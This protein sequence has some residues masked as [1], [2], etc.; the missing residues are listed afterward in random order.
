[1]RLALA[2]DTVLGRRVAGSL[3]ARGPEAPVASEVV[4][5]ARVELNA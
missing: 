3:G 5:A 1:L 4:A 2:G